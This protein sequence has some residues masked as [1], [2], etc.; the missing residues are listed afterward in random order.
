M[1][2]LSAYIVALLVFGAIDAVWLTVM[3]AI[4]YKPTLGDILLT[5]LRI[6]PAIAF[7]AIF[8][9]GIVYFAVLPALKA[10]SLSTALVNGLLLGA[11]AYATYD[12]TNFATL[13]NWTLQITVLDIFWGAFASAIAC[14]VG[15]QVVTKLSLTP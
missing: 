13:R 7:Y 15:Y 1:L 9:A 12:L 3:G 10:D 4:L 11:L 5:T 2:F 8:P 14:G 6:P